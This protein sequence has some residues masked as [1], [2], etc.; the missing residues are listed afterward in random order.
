VV[1]RVRTTFPQVH[2]VLGLS[3]VSFGLPARALVNRTFLTLALPP[4][5]TPP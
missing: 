4:A 1:R 5:S 2:I 3:N